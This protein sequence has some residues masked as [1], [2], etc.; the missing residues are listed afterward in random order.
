MTD[1]A[2]FSEVIFAVVADKLPVVW[3]NTVRVL[4]LAEKTFA[5]VETTRL[6]KFASWFEVNVE[7]FAVTMFAVVTVK[8]EYTI[9]RLILLA[10]VT[11][12]YWSM[13]S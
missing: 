6:L 8:F 4:I 3:S 10:K 2:T 11:L 12:P 1:V 5:F 9:G 13:V 7:I